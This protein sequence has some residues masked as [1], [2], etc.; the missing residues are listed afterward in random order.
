[1]TFIVSNRYM[2]SRTSNNSFY[3]HSMSYAFSM[4]EYYRRIQQKSD[5]QTLLV[6]IPTEF[7]QAIQL[8]KAATVKMRLRDKTIVASRAT[9]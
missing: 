3:R 5:G 2:S 7:A 8:Q 4:Q 1:M 9:N 6:T